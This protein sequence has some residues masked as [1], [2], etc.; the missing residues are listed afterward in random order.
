MLGCITEQKVP[1][2]LPFTEHPLPGSRCY[3]LLSP[4]LTQGLAQSRH[5]RGG[6]LCS[7]PGVPRKLHSSLSLLLALSPFLLVLSQPT[8]FP[9]KSLK[10]QTSFV[11][12]RRFWIAWGWIVTNRPRRATCQGQ[13]PVSLLSL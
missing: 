3:Y 6:V 9:Q 4:S 7:S 10:K 1:P 12:Q 2:P 13:L 5:S 8:G 11:N